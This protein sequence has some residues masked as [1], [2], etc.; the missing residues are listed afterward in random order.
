MEYKERKI[1]ALLNLVDDT[2]EDIISIVESE[3][4]QNGKMALSLIDEYILNAEHPR[5]INRLNKV[6]HELQ[7]S[8]YS[9]NFNKWLRKNDKDLISAIEIITSVQFEQ[10]EKN[11]FKEAILYLKD[12]F[13]LEMSP[14]MNAFEKIRA[15][16][17][18][19]FELFDL[20]NSL[21]NHLPHYHFPHIALEEQTGSNF[22][23][24][25]IYTI[26]AHE[27]D[28]PVYILS[29]SIDDINLG[30][31]DTENINRKI[32][33]KNDEILF[34]I[35]ISNKGRVTP[36]ILSDELNLN[37]LKLISHTEVVRQ[38]L[39]L[40]ILSYHRWQNQGHKVENLEELLY[41]LE[42]HR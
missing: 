40:L 39:C 34:Y 3:I 19:F 35:D 42:S 17:K 29:P 7:F 15:F 36:S 27:L 11:S 24:A 9:S 26:V 25:L 22:S 30:Y 33:G 18:L 21:E 20:K 14:R 1:A 32:G 41:L 2:D 8:E 37:G 6:K 16:N 23:L 28:L 13:W 38:Y 5:L 31:V 12:A 4:K 10:F